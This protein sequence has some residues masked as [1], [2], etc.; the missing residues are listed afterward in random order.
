MQV[1]DVSIDDREWLEGMW[2]AH[3]DRIFAYAAR[4]IGPQRAEDVVSDT[5]VVA[6]R[7]RTHRPHRELPWLYGVARRVI[8]DR[9][10][11]E[12]RWKKLQQR[13]DATRPSPADAVAEPASTAVAAHRALAALD[14]ADRETLLLVSWEGL[15]AREASAALG[16]TPAAFRMRLARARRRLASQMR[17]FGVDSPD[18]SPT[19]DGG[20]DEV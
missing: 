18:L 4:R 17:T 3:A 13:V 6:W 14:E 2:S 12:D 1:L 9:Y 7:H 10:R 5:F 8:R 19:T 20:H 16:I 11:S 15:D